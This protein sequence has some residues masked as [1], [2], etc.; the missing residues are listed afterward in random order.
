MQ[1]YSNNGFAPAWWMESSNLGDAITPF[2]IEQMT[3]KK[4]YFVNP[5]EDVKKYMLTGS[6]LNWDVKNAVVFGCGLASKTDV[7]PTGKDIHGV[8]GV[9]T[10]EILK[11]QNIPFAEVYG[12]PA[13]MLPRFIKPSKEYEKTKIGVLPHYVDQHKVISKFNDWHN[14]VLYIDIL[15][16]LED[17][18]D[19]INQCRIVYSSTLHGIIF[20]HAY[21]IPCYWTKFSDNVLGDGMKFYDHYTSLYV[22]VDEVE[23]LDLR[24]LSHFH[25]RELPKTPLIPNEDTIKY[26]TERLFSHFPII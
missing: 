11:R 16:S 19:Q 7:V 13:L 10:G 24:G 21:G 20:C 26:V 15:G 23:C 12:D 18:V 9:L 1:P 4:A 14:D 17:L 25:F 5:Q 8:R 22:P 2:I 3:G 6:I